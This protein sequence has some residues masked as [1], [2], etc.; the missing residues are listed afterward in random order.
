MS[1]VA[2]RCC[3]FIGAA[4][5]LLIFLVSTAPLRAQ[6]LP[7]P[8]DTTGWTTADDHRHM[9]AQLGIRQLRPGP[10]ADPSAPNAANYDEAKAN[11]YPRL[12]D[13]LTLRSGA[14][15]TTADVW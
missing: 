3:A 10:T 2:V 8:V 9:L 15:V 14:K 4:V 5:L 6:S 11:P 13:P 7:S 12:P 1:S